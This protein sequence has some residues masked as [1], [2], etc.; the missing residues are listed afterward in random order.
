MSVDGNSTK[1]QNDFVKPDGNLVV[2]V[3]EETVPHIQQLLESAR[4]RGVPIAY[5]Q[6][7]QV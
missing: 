6:D 4:A 7:S 1:V 5:T 2:A 3:A